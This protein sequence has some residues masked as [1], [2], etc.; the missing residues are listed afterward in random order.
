SINNKVV[1]LWHLNG[2]L[3]APIS[4]VGN[5]LITFH[6]TDQITP[7]ELNIINHQ[8]KIIVTSKYSKQVFEDFGAKNVEYIELGFDSNNF[9]KLNRRAYSD[10]RIVFG[11]FG[12]LEH[13]K[14]HLKTLKAWAHKYGNNPNY[15][16]HAAIFN[17]FL[18]P[19]DQTKI[20]L[21]GL[22]GKKY[23]NINFIPH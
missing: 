9:W 1:K 5:Y 11:L 20:I 18:S 13:R 2:G 21:N 16:M 22:E 17:P 7:T 14:H 4:K 19:E 12:K 6:E 15:V 23:W 8:E 3:D 10:D